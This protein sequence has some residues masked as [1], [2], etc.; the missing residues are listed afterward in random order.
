[1]FV[2]FFLF[3]FSQNLFLDSFSRKYIFINYA[4]AYVIILYIT[5]PIFFST[6]CF[7]KEKFNNFRKFFRLVAEEKMNRERRK[8]IIYFFKTYVVVTPAVV[9]TKQVSFYRLLFV[10]FSSEPTMRD[11]VFPLLK[12]LCNYFLRCLCAHL[13]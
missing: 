12:C 6:S 8:N 3:E 10:L 13:I 11:G 1:M 5:S 4:F 7:S 2:I 9:S